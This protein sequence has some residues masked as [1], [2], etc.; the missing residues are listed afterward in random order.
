MS[1]ASQTQ[2][3]GWYHAHGDPPGTQRYWNGTGW[4]GDAQPIPGAEIPGYGV[5]DITLADPI[6]R[7]AARLVDLVV[8]AVFTL[9]ISVPFGVSAAIGDSSTT[10]DLIGT[11]LLCVVITIYEVLFITFKGGTP[12]KLLLKT[13]VVQKNGSP[14]DA[15]NAL[16]RMLTY[17]V[18]SLLSLIP[19]VGIPVLVLL[20]VASVVM[21]FIDDS[22]QTPWDKVG[23]TIV[24]G[25]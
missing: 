9:I 10:D 14:A 12:G 6:Q 2:P 3:P 25:D 16:R 11:V 15:G 18:Y 8:W 17:I 21:L 20:A 4:I 1:D 5:T 13:R 19:V 22:H 24:V 7:A 23:D